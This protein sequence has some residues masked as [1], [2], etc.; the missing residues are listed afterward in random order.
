M[1]VEI[2]IFNSMQSPKVP[3][4]LA[5]KWNKN[6]LDILHISNTIEIIRAY[7]NLAKVK[8][9]NNKYRSFGG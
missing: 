2:G 7:N 6:N 3:L 8:T 9:P 5:M 4:S 1:D